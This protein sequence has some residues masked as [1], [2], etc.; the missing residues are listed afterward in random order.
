[1]AKRTYEK[2]SR[3]YE[4]DIQGNLYEREK[5]LDAAP[6]AV[7]GTCI[8]CRREM[9]GSKGQIMRFHRGCRKKGRHLAKMF[10]KVPPL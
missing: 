8:V 2:L 6:K 10:K 9:I 3:T 1:M 5:I 7:I 4:T